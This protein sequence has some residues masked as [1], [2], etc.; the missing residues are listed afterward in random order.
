[1]HDVTDSE[2]ATIATFPPV[3]VRRVVP[4]ETA[5]QVRDALVDVV[6]KKGTA[7]LAAVPG[8]KVAGKTGTAEKIIPG[9]SYKDGKY[10]VSFVGFMPAEN[11]EFVG[12]VLLDEAQAKRGEHYGGQVA[13]PIFSRIAERTARYLNLVPSP[14]VP[15]GGTVIAADTRR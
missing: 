11:P 14:E 8:F 9:G 15:E 7:L 1:V 13:A 12:I 2:G 6:S 3:E 4:E 5:A 10:V